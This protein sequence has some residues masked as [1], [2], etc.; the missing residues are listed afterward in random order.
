[1]KPGS[2]KISI[3]KKLEDIKHSEVIA[4]QDIMRTKIK[5]RMNMGKD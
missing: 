5:E 1:M 2:R 4:K 3:M